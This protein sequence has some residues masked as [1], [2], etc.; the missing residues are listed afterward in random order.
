MSFRYCF[1]FIHVSQS[2]DASFVIFCNSFPPF[3]V[4]FLNF[5]LVMNKLLL[6]CVPVITDGHI[7]SFISRELVRLRLQLDNTWSMK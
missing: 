7:P 5:L 1:E 4:G 2:L 6:K 3:V